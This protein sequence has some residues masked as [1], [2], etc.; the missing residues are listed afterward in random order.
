MNNDD[1]LDREIDF[2][3]GVRGKFYRPGMKL[4]IPVY[5]EQ[6]VLD[7]LT[8]IAGRKGV[9]LDDLVNDL[10]RRELAIA[11]TLR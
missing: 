2:S 6:A 4:H 8:E 3:K 1:P 7:S 5:L 10:L 11:E 9:P